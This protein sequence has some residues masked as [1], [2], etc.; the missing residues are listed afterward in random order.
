MNELIYDKRNGN[1]AFRESDHCYFDLRDPNKKYVSV[2][3]CIHNY[4]EEFDSFFWSRYKALEALTGLETFSSSGIKSVLL[5]K[6]VWSDTYASKCG[7]D[8]IEVH[9]EGM[10]IEEGYRKNSE[11]AC[12]YGTAYHLQQELQFYKEKKD[13]TFNLEFFDKRFTKE[14][15]CIK[16][17]YELDIE[18]GI[19]P[20]Y[21][22][23]WEE[24][25][26]R[27]SGQIDLL[28][29]EGNDIYLIDYKTNAKGIEEKS[30]YNHKT[31]SH[32][33]MKYPVNSL[34]DCD[35]MHYTLQLSFYAKLLQKINPEFKIKLLLLKH[36]SRDGVQTNIEL[37]YL[38]GEVEKIIKDVKKKNYIEEQRNKR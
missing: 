20:E 16:D 9:K 5:D 14:Y 34:M 35:K 13:Q 1:V 27:I 19:Y 28:I 7:I 22:I 11:A 26:L 3:T 24:D 36:C 33:M 25:N 12:A 37:E 10:I 38:P 15:I 6:K 8:P 18:N 29:K 31:K 17:Y 32:K 23:Y 30:Y 2:T 4:I 21:L